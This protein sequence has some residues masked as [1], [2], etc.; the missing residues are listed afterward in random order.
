MYDVLYTLQENDWFNLY[1]F[2]KFICFRAAKV[3]KLKCEDL[4]PKDLSPTIFLLFLK[5]P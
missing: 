3:K 1:D 2:K 4:M 5:L